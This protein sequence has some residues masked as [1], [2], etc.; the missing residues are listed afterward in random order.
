VISGGPSERCGLLPGDRIIT[1]DDS[2]YVG[3]TITNEKVLKNL[4]GAK[5]TV[6]K[7]GVQRR[8]ERDL[9]TFEVE[10][11]DIPLHRRGRIS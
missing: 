11:G 10:R 4:R 5:G 6:V 9:L 8:G 7:L 1:V 2:L 3:K